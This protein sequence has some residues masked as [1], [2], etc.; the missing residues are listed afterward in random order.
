M[1]FPQLDH[2]PK[3]GGTESFPKRFGKYYKQRVAGWALDRKRAMIY[4][5]TEP[6]GQILQARPG[7]F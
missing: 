3:R 6:P 5:K 7:G 1:A 4:H 2:Q